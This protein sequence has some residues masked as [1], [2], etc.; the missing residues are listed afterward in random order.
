VVAHPLLPECI[1]LH[2]EKR[3][4]TLFCVPKPPTSFTHHCYVDRNLKKRMRC[5]VRRDSDFQSTFRKKLDSPWFPTP[6]WLHCLLEK[7][8]FGRLV[9]LLVIGDGSSC[10]STGHEPNPSILL[11]SCTDLSTNQRQECWIFVASSGSELPVIQY[12]DT[13]R[14]L[15]Q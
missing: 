3:T 1:V 4:T 8:W 13:A 5:L 15:V 10:H 9:T 7:V 14:G 2:L 6:L 12:L 11:G